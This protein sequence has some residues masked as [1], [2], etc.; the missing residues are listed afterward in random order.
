VVSRSALGAAAAMGAFWFF[1]LG[2]LGLFFPFFS[3]YL[4]ENAGLAGWQIGVLLGTTPMVAIAAQPLWG[5]LADR[6]GSRARVLGVLCLGAA[7][8]FAGLALG[9]SFAWLLLATVLLACFSTPM[10]PTAISV[11]FA[12]TQDM[13]AHA[14]GLC[15]VWGTFGFGVAVV[16]FPLALDA[17]EA[18]AG[19]VAS[20]GGPSE[21]ALRA[22][23]PA[24]GAIVLVAALIAL[25]LPRA[26]ALAVRAERGDWK[27]LFAH[28]PYVRLLVVGLLGYLLLQGPMAL[29]PVFVRAHGG[30]LD[31]VSRL[32]ILML[33]LEVPLIAL[34]GASLQRLGARGLL[35]MG[36]A[37]GAVRWI[38]CGFAPESAWVV[39]VQALHGVV[40]A[41]LVIGGP[42]YVEAVVP[43]E[44]RSTG[45]NVLAM[46]GVSLGGLLSNLGAGVL[47]D[48]SGPDAPYRVGGV[49]A[50]VVAMLLPWWLPAP[51]RAAAR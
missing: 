36:L 47:L 21:P 13:G 25:T 26:D 42:L 34:S 27:R 1:C 51:S 30:S 12:I 6:T 14:F 16:T 17:I 37:A 9:T 5:A 18:S 22:M 40:V 3:L 43:G 46:V 19:L 10:I 11:T 48:L 44:L 31:T 45:Q 38:V 39:P 29:F 35:A 33:A 50:L 8:G 20:A 28:P 15:R 32:W 23:F 41:G 24:T 49:G 4:R 2:S 7:V